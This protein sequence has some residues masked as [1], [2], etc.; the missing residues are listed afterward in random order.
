ML[1]SGVIH[2]YDYDA[3]AAIIALRAWLTFRYPKLDK[4]PPTKWTVEHANPLD[5]CA[6]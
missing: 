2:R 5:S 6:K 3:N 1:H 4:E